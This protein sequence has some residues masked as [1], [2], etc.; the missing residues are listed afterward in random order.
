MSPVLYN[1]YPSDPARLALSDQARH[2]PWGLPWFEFTNAD[3]CATNDEQRA[4]RDTIVINGSAEGLAELAALFLDAGRP[5]C[6]RSEFV[7]EDSLAGLGGVAPSSAE[8]R[9]SLPGSLRWGYVDPPLT[10]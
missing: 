5:G 3:R 1:Y 4:R 8:A 2:S 10:E 9:F 6:T 7:L